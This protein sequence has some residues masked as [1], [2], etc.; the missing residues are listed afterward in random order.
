MKVFLR[1]PFLA[2]LAIV[3]ASAA[4][5]SCFAQGGDDNKVDS[6]GSHLWTTL[7]HAVA[8]LLEHHREVTP[9][10]VAD[11]VVEV[12]SANSGNPAFDEEAFD[13]L[14]AAALKSVEGKGGDAGRG[15]SEDEHGGG[16]GEEHG[17]EDGEEHGGEHREDDGGEYREEDG[18]EY[19]E[20]DGG[21]Y[22]EDDGGEDGEDHGGEDGEDHGGEDGEDHG[23]EDGEDHGGEDGEDHGGDGAMRRRSLE[24][25]DAN[26]SA[27]YAQ[28]SSCVCAGLPRERA[29]R[30]ARTVVR[31]ESGPAPA[32][33]VASRLADTGVPLVPNRASPPFARS[34][35][36]PRLR[37]RDRM[38]A[39]LLPFSEEVVSV[40]SGLCRQQ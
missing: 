2:A 31:I 20:D 22:R 32:V 13:R 19:R 40:K 38:A 21:E 18:G 25:R 27:A 11:V 15:P 12:K 23:G 17:G 37:K 4:A 30:P 7:I 39:G 36:A 26:V 34:A 10:T 16:Y 35:A 9:A 29:R 8:K 28:C 33:A 5:P 24:K 3:A 14:V 6:V 1:L